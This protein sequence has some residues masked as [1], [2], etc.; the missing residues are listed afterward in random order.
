MAYPFSV[1]ASLASFIQFTF[2]IGGTDAHPKE[3]KDEIIDLEK[4]LKLPKVILTEFKSL[5]DEHSN[6]S[7]CNGQVDFQQVQGYLEEC[8]DSFQGVLEKLKQGSATKWSEFR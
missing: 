6:P 5:L 8:R 4:Q 3:T 1:G 2:Q 7:S